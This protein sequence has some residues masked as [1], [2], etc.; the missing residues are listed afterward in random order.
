M[1][2]LPVSGQFSM[3]EIKP[4]GFNLTKIETIQFAVLEDQHREAC[5]IQYNHAFNVGA[6]DTNKTVQISFISNFDCEGHAF[7][8]FELATTFD[9]N[10]AHFDDLFYEEDKIRIPK[11][12]ITHLL[13]LAI[14]IARGVLFEK[15]RSTDFSEIYIPSINLKELVKR[16][17]VLEKEENK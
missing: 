12:F 8:V 11:D 2:K 17:A 13:M 9:V 6:D 4:I 7:I 10:P 5:D 1:S 14:G 16:D 15:L 3:E